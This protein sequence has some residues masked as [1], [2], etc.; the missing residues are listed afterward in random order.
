MRL[1]RLHSTHFRT[2]APSTDTSGCR[3]SL[4]AKG[5]FVYVRSCGLMSV[6][7]WPRSCG[8]VM[9]D[10]GTVPQTTCQLS[11]TR[12]TPRCG[13]PCLP[14]VVGA[15]GVVRGFETFVLRRSWT[16][17]TWSTSFPEYGMDGPGGG[18]FGSSIAAGRVHALKPA[19]WRWVLPLMDSTARAPGAAVSPADRTGYSTPLGGAFAL[20]KPK[21]LLRSSQNNADDSMPI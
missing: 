3:H 12:P 18:C 11:G 5:G 6:A 19:C 1:Q 8:R 2:A 17:Q 13:C 21:Q 4:S 14:T 10:T 20:K 7:V 16:A 15:P 9:C